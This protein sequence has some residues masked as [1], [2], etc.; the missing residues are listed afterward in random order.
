M[1]Y[2]LNNFIGDTLYVLE[3]QSFGILEFDIPRINSLSYEEAYKF[4]S[5]YCINDVEGDFEA[6]FIKVTPYVIIGIVI[7]PSGFYD[8]HSKVNKE[9]NTMVIYKCYKE[10]D[11]YHTRR[12]DL[13]PQGEKSLWFTN[14]EE[15]LNKAKEF[16]KKKLWLNSHAYADER[17]R[18]I[19][20]LEEVCP[21]DD[22][23]DIF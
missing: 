15:A 9:L 16:N 8:V 13:Y 18:C 19:E 20:R 14:K 22:L 6:D 11:I 17:K 3:K 5:T 4:R 2:T 7:E 12:L 1:E 23:R 21:W 10:N